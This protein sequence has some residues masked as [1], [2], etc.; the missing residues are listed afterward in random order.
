[1]QAMRRRIAACLLAVVGVSIATPVTCA[2]WQP[3]ADERLACCQ[4]AAHDHCK[5]QRAADDCCAG[6]E[7]QQQP[8]QV[9]A[10]SAMPSILALAFAPASFGSLAAAPTSARHSDPF[11]TLPPDS[12]PGFFGPPL[13]I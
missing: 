6:A 9:M 8:A 11:F 2:G 1:M 4:R 5:D 13:R 12:P 10:T 3:R 7:Q